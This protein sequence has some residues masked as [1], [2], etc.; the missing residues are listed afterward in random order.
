MDLSYHNSIS[1]FFI[2]IFILKVWT[3]RKSLGFSS[4]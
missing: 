4:N 2:V 3:K 1:K